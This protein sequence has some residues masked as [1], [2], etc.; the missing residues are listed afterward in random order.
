[1]LVNPLSVCVCVCLCMWPSLIASIWQHTHI[2]H[3]HVNVLKLS[4][5]NGSQAEMTDWLLYRSHYDN[6]TLLLC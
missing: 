6:Q 4:G 3:P 2:H 5:V 1:M